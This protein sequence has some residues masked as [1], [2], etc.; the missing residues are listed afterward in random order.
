RRQ[1]ARHL[2]EIG[3]DLLH[4]QVRP[5][6]HHESEAPRTATSELGAGHMWPEGVA[7]DR[8]LDAADR[9]R[10]HARTVVQDAIDRREAYAS[11]AGDVPEREMTVGVRLLHGLKVSRGYLR[12]ATHFEARQRHPRVTCLP[13]PLDQAS[14]KGP[15]TGRQG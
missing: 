5:R 12:Y 15:R 9:V 10:P 11:L 7:V 6:R 4:E 8:L 2:A 3:L 13:W 14:G 1:P